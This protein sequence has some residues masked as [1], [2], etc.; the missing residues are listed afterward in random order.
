MR[1]WNQVID[2]SRANL[3]GADLRNADLSG[4]TRLNDV[5][6]DRRGV[7]LHG[8]N[9]T[10]ADLTRANL[11]YVDLEQS[12][13]C[14]A[15][16]DG[17][18]ILALVGGADFRGATLRGADLSYSTLHNVNFEFCDL[19]D[20]DFSMCVFGANVSL[21]GAKLGNAKFQM[22]QGQVPKMSL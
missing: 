20:V 21:H 1:T 13:L 10:E 16:L 19:R 15:C 2:L 18:R 11:T 6:R 3:T 12:Q 5:T 4:E 14:G 22:A 9:L 17:A 8:A 7:R